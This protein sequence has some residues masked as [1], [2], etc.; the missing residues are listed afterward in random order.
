M[1]LQLFCAWMR[2]GL[3][4]HM[5]SGWDGDMH[6]AWR[7]DLKRIH[8]LLGHDIMMVSR[9]VSREGA[10][11]QAM[12]GSY[13][14][15]PFWTARHSWGRFRGSLQKRNL[16]VEGACTPHREWSNS[17]S[18]RD[19]WGW[20]K[21]TSSPTEKLFLVFLERRLHHQYRESFWAF[22]GGGFITDIGS[23]FLG[24]LW[25]S[26]S[27]H[28]KRQVHNCRSSSPPLKLAGLFI[29]SHHRH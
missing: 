15:S 29:E 18:S 10:S 24:V 7:W 22:F 27:S 26:A 21:E 28:W 14:Q 5:C 25:R 1:F 19:F 11:P 20:K 12:Q 8:F 9:R 3:L 4:A 23:H 2:L 17:R 16:S 13:Y 6:S